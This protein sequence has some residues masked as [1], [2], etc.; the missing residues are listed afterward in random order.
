MAAM[1][2]VGVA[3]E[4]A[5]GWLVFDDWQ[6]AYEAA[7]AASASERVSFL[8]YLSGERSPWMNPSARGGWLGLGLG[9]TRGA[10]MRAAFEGVAF[11]L[12]AGL[13]AVRANANAGSI[14]GIRTLR[15]A[16]GGS[17]DPRWRQMLAD[18]LDADL[19]AVDS[20]N[21]ATRGAALLGGLAVGHW[22]AADLAKLAPSALP[23]ATP[24]ADK[25]LA[26]RHARF[27]DLYKRTASWF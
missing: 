6:Q 25:A 18:A 5:R 12:R 26:E 19:Q 16:G 11:S 22:H 17:I 15:L 13:D 23:V 10:M 8:P 9:D 1:Q 24:R 2:N 3:L 4:A 20:P 27:I 7:F 21:A 14:A